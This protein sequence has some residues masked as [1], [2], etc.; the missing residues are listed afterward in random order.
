MSFA[1]QT[2]VINHTHPTYPP[3]WPHE[4]VRITC[5]NCKHVTETDVDKKNSMCAWICVLVMFFTG[6]WLCCCIPCCLDS[7]KDTMH[8][9]KECDTIVGARLQNDK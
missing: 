5:H 2:V 8:K 4:P 3:V 7:C 9:C 6:L 1:K